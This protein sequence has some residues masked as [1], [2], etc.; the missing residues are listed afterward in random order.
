V[1]I[2]V[3][4]REFP[5][6]NN[7][8]VLLDHFT[9]TVDAIYRILHVP[10]TWRWLKELYTDLNS[11]RLPS[12][13]QLAFFLGI[14]AGSAYMSKSDLQ[15]ELAPLSG[16]SPIA[17]AESWFK[18]AVLLLTKPPVPPSTQGLQTL[19]NLIH[20]CTQIEGVAGSFSILSMS[21]L[22]MA[23]LMRVHR[24]DAP[25][26]R[27]ER[28]KNGA[29]MVDIEVKRRIWWHLVASDWLVFYNSLQHYYD[30]PVF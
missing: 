22:Q 7:G 15:F 17:L 9:K 13:T 21:G 18:Q 20:L 29:D 11:N 2:S 10:T 28:G 1:D 6:Y 12:A 4:L 3:I 19:T 23:R 26:Y 8:E 27:K 14:F 24:L 25:R 30:L 16:R 5:T